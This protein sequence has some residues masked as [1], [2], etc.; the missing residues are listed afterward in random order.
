MSS[1]LLLGKVQGISEDEKKGKQG[2][3]RQSIENLIHC[4]S[5]GEAIYEP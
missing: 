2:D 3:N 4:V 5:T 1:V